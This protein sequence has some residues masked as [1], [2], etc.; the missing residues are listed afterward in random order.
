MRSEASKG[1]IA[2]SKSTQ[3]VSV[4][5]ADYSNL[6]EFSQNIQKWFLFNVNVT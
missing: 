6:T 3:N 4:E 1:I 2:L 5:S